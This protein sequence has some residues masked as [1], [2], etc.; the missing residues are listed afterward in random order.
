MTFGRVDAEFWAGDSVWISFNPHPD[1]GEGDASQHWTPPRLLL[2]RPGHTL[3]YPSLQPLDTPEDVA[4]RHTSVRLGRRARLWVKDLGPSTH[5]YLS[6][7]V[8]TFG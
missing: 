4:Q 6:E 8:V 1:L 7:Y 2:R 5:R 3:W